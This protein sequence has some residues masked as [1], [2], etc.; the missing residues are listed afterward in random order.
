[1]I[2][3]SPFCCIRGH[4]CAPNHRQLTRRRGSC[5]RFFRRQWDPVQRM[6]LVGIVAKLRALLSTSIENEEQ[7]L[8]L[9][10]HTRKALDAEPGGVPGFSTL[11]FHCDWMVHHALSGR[12]AAT[13]IR[14]VDLYQDVIVD[15]N[16]Q[17]NSTTLDAAAFT[18]LAEI[19]DL[20]YFRRLRSELRA[21]LQ[22]HQLPEDVIADDQWP[23]FLK[24][25]ISA[26][27]SS[28]LE[29]KPPRT[30][31]QNAPLPVP[32]DVQHVTVSL[33]DYKPAGTGSDFRVSWM[34]DWPNGDPDFP[35]VVRR[36]LFI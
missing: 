26:I 9:L 35:I 12:G 18:A 16:M 28:P 5:L 33:L 17:E 3:F 25:Y 10:V 22:R 29:Y 1:M 14:H 34:W 6:P 24:L 13:L 20:M 21:F 32:P 4:F 8:S 30:Q 19:D 11:R 31:Y 15:S 36:V 2:R 7:L 23:E 27:Q